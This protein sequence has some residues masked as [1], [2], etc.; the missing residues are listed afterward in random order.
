MITRFIPVGP[1]LMVALALCAAPVMSQS[2]SPAEQA[3]NEKAPLSEDD[4][5][6]RALGCRI[7]GAAQARPM[8]LP[9]GPSGRYVVLPDMAFLK[10]AQL[11]VS[12][13]VS[14]D[15]ALL[16]FEDLPNGGIWPRDFCAVVQMHYEGPHMLVGGA[17]T[18]QGLWLRNAL[19]LATEYPNT[20]V[21]VADRGQLDLV[22][23]SGY[24]ALNLA[25]P[26]VQT[27]WQGESGISVLRRP[28][29]P[30]IQMGQTLF[31]PL[32]Q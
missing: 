7:G 24:I 13:A 16:A 23:S 11:V 14:Q 17:V 15:V 12:D 28:T 2:L 5:A 25:D 8:T 27:W 3:A 31:F 18:A 22:P 4:K 26:A 21:I 29:A 1:A 30:A 19:D 10:I 20:S 32:A 9:E 6:L